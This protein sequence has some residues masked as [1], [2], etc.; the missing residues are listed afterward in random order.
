MS[1]EELAEAERQLAEI[2]AVEKDATFLVTNLRQLPRTWNLSAALLNA[3]DSE[4]RL[5]A[6]RRELAGRIMKA[7]QAPP[8]DLI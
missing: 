7:K 4:S 8:E 2:E 6:E 5:K 3:E 1:D